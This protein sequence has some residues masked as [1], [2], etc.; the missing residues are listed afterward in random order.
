MGGENARLEKRKEFAFPCRAR[1]SFTTPIPK[2]WSPAAIKATSKQIV[3]LLK[4]PTD[5]IIPAE[6][7]PLKPNTN[8]R[9]ILDNVDSGHLKRRP[10]KITAICFSF[11]FELDLE[12]RGQ[13]EMS[14]MIYRRRQI[15]QE[16]AR[17]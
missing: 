4:G 6:V 3:S 15:N 12:C 17:L 5:K 2:K 1:S 16:G 14:R 7:T 11:N 9:F 8:S 10:D 13:V